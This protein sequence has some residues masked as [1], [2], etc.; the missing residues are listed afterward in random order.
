VRA[1]VNYRKTLDAASAHPAPLLDV[2]S[3]Y[4]YL[5]NE[6]SFPASSIIIMSESA[7]SHLNLLLNRYIHFLSLPLPSALLLNS[8]WCNFS[9]YRF[10]SPVTNYRYDYLA[11]MGQRAIDSGMRWFELEARKSVWFS[12]ALGSGADWEY[13]RDG[14][15]RVYVMRG[16]KEI[17]F[18]EIGV[19]VEGMKA[20]GV[21]VTL[22]DVSALL[23]RRTMLMWDVFAWPIGCR[24]IARWTSTSIQG[25]KILASMARRRE[26]VFES[27]VA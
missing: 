11:F 1:G 18:D 15:V 22:R 9:D 4:L 13:L 20:A 19:L 14:G 24:W 23:G 2:L 27:I 26:G 17:L 16:G 25:F 5:L 12:P 8:P 6:L 10:E 7:G 21:D 3:C